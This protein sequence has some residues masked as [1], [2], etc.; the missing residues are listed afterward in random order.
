MGRQLQSEEHIGKLEERVQAAE[1]SL[2]HL[3][4]AHEA[5]REEMQ[6][7]QVALWLS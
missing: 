4:K 7:G 2:H 1:D 6:S 5:M 3:Q